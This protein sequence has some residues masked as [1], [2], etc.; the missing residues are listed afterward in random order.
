MCILAGV[1]GRR[2]VNPSVA[3]GARRDAPSGA[4]IAAT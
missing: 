2:S 3:V 1:R 4:M